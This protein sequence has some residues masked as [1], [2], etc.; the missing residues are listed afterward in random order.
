[1]KKRLTACTLL[2]VC[3]LMGCSGVANIYDDNSRIAS[4][5]NTFNLDAIEQ[6]IQGTTFSASVERMEGMDTVWTMESAETT[7]IDIAYD[8]T[9]YSGKVKLVLI[10]PDGELTTLV[11]CTSDTN[12]SD[13][14]TLSLQQGEYRIKLVAG[15]NTK[16]DIS[17]S[18]TDGTLHELGL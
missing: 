4:D 17:L 14:T 7:D 12:S 10:S 16:F 3:L 1:M 15:E 13:N 8:I 2:L 9:S 5:T 6:E 18:V 11:E